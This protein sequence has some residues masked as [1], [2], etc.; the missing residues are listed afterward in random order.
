MVYLVDQMLALHRQL[1]EAKTSHE[2]TLIQHQIAATDRQ[3]R[4]TG[5]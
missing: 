3:D 4:Q 1:A 2:Q 5:L